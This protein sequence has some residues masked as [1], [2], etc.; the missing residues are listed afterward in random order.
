MDDLAASREWQ[1]RR[2]DRQIRDGGFGAA[3]R[4][5]ALTQQR[6]QALAAAIADYRE[7]RKG[8]EIPELLAHTDNDTI[9]VA[10]IQAAIHAICVKDRKKS[11]VRTS[12]RIGRALERECWIADF[13]AHDRKLARKIEAKA[14]RRAGVPNRQSFARW[15]AGK[16]GYE[17]RGWD[18]ATTHK[19]G[20]WASH[21]LVE[22]LPD[23][24]AYTG[25]RLLTLTASAIEFMQAAFERGVFRN[26][27]FFPLNVE[28]EP[29][30][31]ARGGGIWDPEQP[32][33]PL[34][35]T[36]H[37]EIEAAVQ[38]AIDA[39]KMQRVLDAVNTLQSVP[40]SIN[41]PVLEFI[42]RFEQ[43]NDTLF[44]MDIGIAELLAEQDRFWTPMNLD[45]R[46][47]VFALSHFK[48]ERED[49]VKALFQFAN[50]AKLDKRGIFWLKCH[51]ANHADGLGLDGVEKPSR[52]PF[53]KKEEWIDK[54]AD[55]LTWIGRVAPN[56]DGPNLIGPHL[57][58]LSKK[59]RYQFLAAAIEFAKAVD[60]PNHESRL[61]VSFD[62]TCSGVQHLAAMTR[63]ERAAPLVNLTPGSHNDLYA[64]VAQHVYNAG[65]DAVLAG[66]DNLEGHWATELMLYDREHLNAEAG[67]FSRDLAKRGTMTF[68]YGSEAYGMTDQLAED[69]EELAERFWA[70]SYAAKKLYAAVKELLPRPGAA[71]DFLQGLA[72]VAAS[73]NKSLQWATPD[74]LP[75]FNHYPQEMTKIVNSFMH[76]R[77]VLV[78]VQT[79]VAV[80]YKDKVSPGKSKNSITANFV[81]SMDGCL[82]R[83]VAVTA[84]A[85]KIQLA[86]VHDCFACLASNADRL[87]TI[88]LDEFAR[89]YEG[90][91][92][93]ASVLDQAKKDLPKIHLPTPPD[94]GDLDLGGIR[95]AQSA[96][97]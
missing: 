60:D 77:G 6:A 59:K 51:L 46:G 45:F 47:R 40:W 35:R 17:R 89:I 26:P 84:A 18:E 62:A 30:T 13:R 52:L 56:P 72:G 19:V 23:V 90:N 4:S 61:P 81:H 95:E 37:P 22:K 31:A 93:L 78:R 25:L 16:Q 68:F 38:A 2:Q 63:D 3:D 41:R 85:A 10:M 64:D 9:A 88:L 49:H 7:Q 57:L 53:D 29:W 73:K 27:A 12:A 86:T 92:V 39:G 15:Y 20:A 96:F 1:F 69:H 74:G 11:F 66:D 44:E 55:T 58:K 43:R 32:P 97:S 28:P 8:H 33:Q 34:V 36:N 50:G 24:F 54:H 79:K 91:D 87:R 76:E 21:L 82:L 94:Y 70:R 71:R 80:G 48:Y 42:K 75:V 83:C 5:L 67:T 14:R 65:L